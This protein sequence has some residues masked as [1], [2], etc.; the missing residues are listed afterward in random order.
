MTSLAQQLKRLSLPQSDASLLSRR[1]VASLLFDPKD[2]AS[3]DRSTFYALGCTGLE[4]LLGIE[5]AFQEFQDTLFSP[6]S[7]TLERSV[8]SRDVN[9]RL[10]AGISLF[11]TRLSP[12]FL[13]KPAHKCIEWLVHRFHVHLYNADSLMVCALP[14]HDTN[15]FVRVLQLL[16]IKDPTN[17]W[18]WLHQLQKPGVPL[19]RRTLVTHCY[20]DLSFMDFICSMVTSSI[21]AYSSSSGSPPQLRLIFS[22]YVSIVVS[23]L[24]A[25]LK[26]TLT[27]YKAASYM[28]VCQLAVKVA[29][30]AGLVDSLAVQ[31]SRSLL[32]EPVLASEGLGCLIVLLQN[33][34][35]G[36]VGPRASGRL[37][38]MPALVS[39]LQTM[40]ATHDVSPLLRY[41]LPHLVHSIFSSEIDQLI[42]LL[43]CHRWKEVE[44]ETDEL[45]VFESILK[46]VP[47]TKSLDQTVAR[48]LLDEYLSQTELSAERSSALQRR[49]LPLVR[50]FESRYCGA[51]DG[52]LSGHVTDIMGDSDT[53]LLL[54]LK[55]PRPS[56]RVSA[57]EH[58]RGVVS[59]GQQQSLDQ[60]FL[61]DAVME[62]LRDDEPPV[63]AATLKLLEVSEVEGAGSERG[64][65]E[66]LMDA[67][68]VEDVTSCLLS[69]LHRVDKSDAQ[70]WLPVLKEAVRLLSDPRLGKGDTEW[71]QRTGW[72]LLPSWW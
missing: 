38:S 37:C 57:V 20:S 21:Q 7:L 68:D 65:G 66:E 5:P 42:Y 41:L 61:R 22:F 27:D 31:V 64:G 8:Q 26:S 6:A 69:L 29:L 13:L 30:E 72:R 17:R 33:Q 44:S 43:L 18:N 55:H 46:S 70:S 34:R 35:E 1:D 3:M 12:Y 9:E 51:L 36:A 58:L 19:S 11:L 15:V 62:R 50:L 14:H 40:A 49:L 60:D 59:S 28:I 53:S 63:V 71:V 16:N 23:A 25:G 67:M 10:D 45:G 52:V 56:V 39:T 4:E 54:S 2:A 47:L 48:L 24:D 32:R